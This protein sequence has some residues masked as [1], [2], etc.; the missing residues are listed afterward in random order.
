MTGNYSTLTLLWG[1]IM[2]YQL[3]KIYSFYSSKNW[4]CGFLDYDTM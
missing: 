3:C 1:K 4:D 2:N